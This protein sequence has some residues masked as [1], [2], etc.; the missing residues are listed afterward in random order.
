MTDRLRVLVT[1]GRNY[2]DAATVY[3]V[4]DEVAAASEFGI[5]ELIHGACPYG[6]ADILA[7]NWAKSR[8]VDYCGRPAK[9][10]SRGGRAGPERNQRMLNEFAPDLVV[11]FPGGRGTAD[12]VSR[13]EA[14]GIPVRHILDGRLRPGVSHRAA[15]R[16]VR[17]DPVR[18]D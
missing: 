14:A 6:G 15:D 7:E 2:K 4:L 8:E 10:K 5:T 11:A 3:R 12:T 17:P 9:F 18:H 13:A 16:P 1:G